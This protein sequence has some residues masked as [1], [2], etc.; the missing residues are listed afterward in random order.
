MGRTGNAAGPS[1]SHK[2]NF[3]MG[4]HAGQ[5]RRLRLSKPK[6]EGS[7]AQGQIGS[8]EQMT[9]SMTAVTIAQAG[10]VKPAPR[11]IKRLAARAPAGRINL[12]FIHRFRLTRKKHLLSFRRPLDC[13]EKQQGKWDGSWAASRAG[14]RLRPPGTPAQSG[15]LRL[16]RCGN[17]H[18][19]FPC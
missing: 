19:A 15:W 4:Q 10:P 7:I 11:I 3:N 14:R 2:P 9:L 1:T 13:L 6:N 8:V 16:N 5:K 17:R 18:S 12:I